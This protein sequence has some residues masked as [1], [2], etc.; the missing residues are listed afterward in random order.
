MT[1]GGPVSQGPTWACFTFEV[2]AGT[3]T[4]VIR[5]E[6]DGTRPY[7]DLADEAYDRAYLYASSRGWLVD[8]EDL[9]SVD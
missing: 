2:G 7:A 9:I 6:D 5:I 4:I 1:A 3:G 8:D